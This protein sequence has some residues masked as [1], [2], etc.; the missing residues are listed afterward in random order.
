MAKNK[1]KPLIVPREIPVTTIDKCFGFGADEESGKCARC[2]ATPTKRGYSVCV[3]CY[4]EIRAAIMNAIRESRDIDDLMER[5]KKIALR[6]VGKSPNGEL[7]ETVR[8]IIR[9]TT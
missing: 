6:S 5:L 3:F 9:S 7:A 4:E 2:G 1:R 8:D